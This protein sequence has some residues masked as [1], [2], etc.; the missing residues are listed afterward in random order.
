MP[1]QTFL[2]P[3]AIARRAPDPVFAEDH[4][5]TR[6]ILFVPVR[7]VP[8]GIPMDA[9]ARLP[10][11]DRHVYREVED[12]LLNKDVVEGTFH[13]KHKGIT[14]LAEKVEQD[15]KD[16]YGV[17]ISSS[18]GI[19]DGGHTYELIKKHLVEGDLPENQFV[20]FE[21]LT[22]I[23]QEWIPEIAGGLNTSV[24][25]QAMS[26]ANLAEKFEWIKEELHEEPYFKKISWKEN[27]E[28]D[29][30][31]RDIISFMTCFNIDQFPNNKDTHPI[32][33]YERKSLALQLFLKYPD[34]YKRLRPILKNIL[35]LH[36][37]IRRDSREYWNDTGGKFGHFAFV[38]Q[39]KK[40][41]T[42]P[43]TGEQSEFRLMNGALFPM[44]A[45][46]R[47]MVEEDPKTKKI[48]WKGGFREVL[49]LWR[50]CAHELVKATKQAN[51]EYGRN[52][53]AIG[54]SRSHWSNLYRN[55]AMR[56]FMA[57]SDRGSE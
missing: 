36:D 48:R 43:F 35:V 37:T 14:V 28:G 19:V 24:Q 12:S 18:Q 15:G 26:L 7:N 32:V 9:N 57:K 56:Y 25:V 49:R 20:K 10:N 53:N 47:W 31:A 42:F 27:E 30:D 23:P 50:S 51:D 21:I 39:R 38:E 1:K 4:G 46:F 5:I 41:F 3:A 29:I 45:A 17:T 33:A 34:T 2:L 44:L 16:M 6:H 55:V 8:N 54:K 40:G 13:L 11:I 52:P 22:H